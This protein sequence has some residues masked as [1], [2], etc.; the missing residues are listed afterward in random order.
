MLM[1]LSVNNDANISEDEV[2]IFKVNP[3]MSK[4]MLKQL[5]KCCDVM[6]ERNLGSDLRRAGEGLDT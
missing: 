6:S 1:N 5:R 4:M 3:S 2:A